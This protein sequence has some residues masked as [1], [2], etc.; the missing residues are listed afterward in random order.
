MKKILTIL[1]LI[2]I[3]FSG[4]GGGGTVNVVPEE[5]AKTLA[6]GIKIPNDQLMEAPKEVID[7]WYSFDEKVTAFTVYVS[8]TGGTANEI[9]VVKSADIKTA[10]AA[11]LKRVED[12]KT[13]FKDY[14][15]A[16]MAK[17]ENPVVASKGDVA[18]LV[19]ADDA[20]SAQKMIDEILK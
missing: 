5:A 16:E 8:A 3:A 10:E 19:L 14:V 17:L 12:L 6:G 7:E 2:L 13:R 15:P 9:A 18:V 11:L 1:L 4:C 20:A